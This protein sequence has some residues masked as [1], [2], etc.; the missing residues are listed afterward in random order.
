M[1]KLVIAYKCAN[2]LKKQKQNRNIEL[3]GLCKIVGSKY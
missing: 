2:H 1:T 3:I